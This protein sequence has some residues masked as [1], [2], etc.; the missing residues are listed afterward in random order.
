MQKRE[1][2]EYPADTI[3]AQLTRHVTFGESIDTEKTD[4]VIK[5]ILGCA[6]VNNTCTTVFLTKHGN[7]LL[8]H[9]IRGEALSFYAVQS[10][11]SGTSYRVIM[12]NMAGGINTVVAGKQSSLS[13]LYVLL[14][15]LSSSLSHFPP[16]KHCIKPDPGTYSLLE[17]H[18][19]EYML[20]HHRRSII[21]W[22]VRVTIE[23]DI[24]FV[25]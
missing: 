24:N 6:P 7:R 2:P 25:H 5:V 8:F 15:S 17:N 11:H 23:G 1:L 22:C 4:I 10:K 9:E 12:W 21:R 19:N 16:V 14:M 18:P 13:P 3:G 20:M